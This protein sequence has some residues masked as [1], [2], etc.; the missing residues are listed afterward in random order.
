MSKANRISSLILISICDRARLPC[1]AET[2][3]SIN[4][5]LESRLLLLTSIPVRTYRL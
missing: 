2:L 1:S 4:G 5:Y 3:R